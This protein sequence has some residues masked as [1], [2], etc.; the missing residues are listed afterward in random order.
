MIE[1]YGYFLPK[2]PSF[3]SVEYMHGVLDSTHYA[4]KYEAIKLRACPRPPPKDEVL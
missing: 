2:N 1:R 4:P 3:C